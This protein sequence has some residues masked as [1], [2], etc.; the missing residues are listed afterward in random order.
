MG[1]WEFRG[2]DDLVQ[3]Q[4][5][6]LG[7]LPSLVLS[8]SP[9]PSAPLKNSFIETS[10]IYHTVYLFKMFSGIFIELCSHHH[11]LIPECFYHPPKESPY[12]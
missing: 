5:V 10:L 9:S 1:C 4:A 11:S 2:Y 8:L 7:S 6:R 12:L 3:W